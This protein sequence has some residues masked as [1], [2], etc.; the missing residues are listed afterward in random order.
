M[1]LDWFYYIEIS[2]ND[3]T[4]LTYHAEDI[5]TLKIV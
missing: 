2:E 3:W 5:K 1:Y 4:S